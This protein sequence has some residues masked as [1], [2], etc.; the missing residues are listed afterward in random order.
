MQ[1]FGGSI[2]KMEKGSGLVAV[3]GTGAKPVCN[4]P[5][6]LALSGNSSFDSVPF[7]PVVKRHLLRKPMCHPTRSMWWKGSTPSPVGEDHDTPAWGSRSIGTRHT[8]RK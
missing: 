8:G 5:C 7:G 2:V 3:K 4:K 6:G 1:L